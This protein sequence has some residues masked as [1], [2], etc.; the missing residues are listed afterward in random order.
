MILGKVLVFHHIPTLS[1]S[2]DSAS[3]RALEYVRGELRSTAEATDHNPVIQSTSE[4]SWIRLYASV[5]VELQSVQWDNIPLRNVA[6][7]S[8]YYTLCLHRCSLHNLD[9]AMSAPRTWQLP[10]VTSDAVASTYADLHNA[11]SLL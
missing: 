8:P 4:Y 5:D 10:P 9:P 2:Y 7:T 1:P 3:S 6:V 11:M